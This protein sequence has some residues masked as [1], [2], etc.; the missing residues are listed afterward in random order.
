[1]ERISYINS[2]DLGSF[3][4][5]E[6]VSCLDSIEDVATLVETFEE[7]R[8][9]VSYKNIE[10]VYKNEYGNYIL[11][12]SDDETD[13]DLT[14]FILENFENEENLCCGNINYI[15]PRR[16]SRGIYE[17]VEEEEEY[18]EEVATSYL[19]EDI[20]LE[21]K[22]YKLVH[23]ATNTVIDVTSKGVVIGRSLQKATYIIRDNTS[24]GRVHCNVYIDADGNLRVHD[25]NSLNGTFVNNTKVF[26]N[27]DVLLRE[28]DY[29]HVVNEKFKVIC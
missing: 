12:V 26:P 20:S 16:L 3:I 9:L 18:E 19:D 25:F 4:G 10:G 11:T 23:S 13:F 14:S 5:L 29:L 17:N 27:E 22:D 21:E 7:A 6:R 15:F 8:D 1:M 24:V 2:K 28:G